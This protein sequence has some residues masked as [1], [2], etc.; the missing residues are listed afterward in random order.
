MTWIVLTLFAAFMQAIRTAGQKSLSNTVSPITATMVRYA[1]G[2]PF[3]VLY[4]W[5]IVNQLPDSILY[6]LKFT[7]RF[8]AYSLAASIMQILATAHLI[9]VFKTRNFAVGTAYAKTEAM[10]TAVLAVS[11]FAESLT[12]AAWISVLMGV[13]G[14]VFISLARQR[15]GELTRASFH[16]VALGL[17]SGLFFSLTSLFLQQA[18]LSL[19]GPAFLTAAVTLVFMVS[20]QTVVTIGWIATADYGQFKKLKALMPVCVFVGITSVAGSIGWFTAMTLQNAAYVKALG[21]VEFIVTLFI[22]GRVFKESISQPEG[23]GLALIV[24]SICL[25]LLGA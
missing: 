19:Q 4:L 9:E 20:V 16:T 7:N 2:L 6:T 25:L 12:L 11:L 14:V 5:I 8:F 18:S 15:A 1:F 13:V 23:V 21:Q 17:L 10:I 24:A 3:A 22:T